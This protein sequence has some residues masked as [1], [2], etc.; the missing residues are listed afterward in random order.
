MT[1]AAPLVL[2]VDAIRNGIPALHDSIYLNTG[3]FGPSPA[4][5]FEEIQDAL[6][7]IRRHGPYSPLVRQ[8]VE[9]ERYE[10]TRLQAAQLM[11]A[12]PDEIVLTRSASDGINL[13]AHGLDWQPGDQVVISSEEH[14]SGTLP[15]LVLARRRGI[16]VRLARLDHDPQSCLQT[17]PSSSPRAPDWCSPAT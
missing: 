7:L 12:S 9:R 8:T 4:V 15:W 5:V 3:T 6:D 16:E 2:D 13:I 10:W 17:L 14:Q 11:G 1:V